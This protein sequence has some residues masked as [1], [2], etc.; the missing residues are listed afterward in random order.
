MRDKLLIEIDIE[1]QGYVCEYFGE[2]SSYSRS[3]QYRKGNDTFVIYMG[4][5][6]GNRKHCPETILD[7]RVMLE[8]YLTDSIETLG[9]N[10][11]HLDWKTVQNKDNSL[12]D[13]SHILNKN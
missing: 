1:K 6:I 10:G 8:Y 13:L 3:T 5:I 2:F 4:T 7:S 12:I 9:N 11:I